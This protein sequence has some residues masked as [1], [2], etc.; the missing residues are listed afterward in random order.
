MAKPKTTTS[1]PPYIPIFWAEWDGSPDVQRM[2]L[3]EEAFYFRFLR[4]QWIL[5]E[6]PS[7]PWALSVLLH[8]RYETTTKW[9]SKWSHLVVKAERKCSEHVV[10]L[11]SSCSK[12]VVTLYNEKLR[13][14]KNDVNS[15]LELGTTK[16]NINK[17]KPK[18][19][20]DV[21]H[22]HHD[23]TEINVSQAEPA[24]VESV[25]PAAVTETAD[26]PDTSKTGKL[27]YDILVFNA[28]RKEF[29]NA[30][31][32]DAINLAFYEL[33]KTHPEKHVLNVIEYMVNNDHYMLGLKSIGK[34]DPWDWFVEKF[35]SMANQ[36]AADEEFKKARKKKAAKG[37]KPQLEFQKDEYGGYEDNAK[38]L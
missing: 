9:L 22:H 32:R 6:L 27:F 17:Q 35:D 5:D 3:A 11:E 38:T 10:N 36:M 4:K 24:A 1:I 13:M 31:N 19:N 15:G 25:K 26:D 29:K 33:Q 21:S 37:D 7:D 34:T 2:S 28:G 12:C 23:N 14:L 20:E 18:L 8:A 30:A 16:P